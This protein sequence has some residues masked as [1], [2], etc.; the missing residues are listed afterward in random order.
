M[1]GMKPQDQS[2]IRYNNTKMILNIIK[3]AHGIARSDL[4]KLTG[5]SAT[6]MTRIVNELLELNLVQE[7]S[8][9]SGGIGRKSIL[10]EIKKDVFYV[11][12]ID[13][14]ERDISVCV[15]DFSGAVIGKKVISRT[16][17]SSLKIE[18]MIR[19]IYQNYQKLLQE[20]KVKEELVAAIG[21]GAI[22]SIDREK[23]LVRY[24][25]LTHTHNIPIKELI[26]SVFKRPAFIDNDIKCAIVAENTFGEVPNLDD[27][28]ML[29]F[30]RGVGSAIINRGRIVRGCTNTA[31]EIGHTI[32]DFSD[33][34]LCICGRRGCLSSYLMEENIIEEA[35]KSNS[36]ICSIADIMECYEKNFLWAISLVDRITNY[37]TIAIN[38][39]VNYLNPR[40]L[41]LGGKLINDNPILY[42]MALKKYSGMISFSTLHPTTHIS[43]SKLSR[44]AVCIGGA[45][46]AQEKHMLKMIKMPNEF[47]ESR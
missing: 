16:T 41:V 35:R 26:E 33:G 7:T 9:S 1:N 43:P 30:G 11:V 2:D 4:A 44:D 45:L 23:G 42:D 40:N 20:F 38:N 19:F 13:F 24:E 5:M 18:E 37:M 21:V 3:A 28:V 6:S 39:A 22:G 46:V 47:I 8:F 34:R 12:G 27:V 25:E 29:S 10:L 31:G 15:M 32:V 17:A 36:S 14:A